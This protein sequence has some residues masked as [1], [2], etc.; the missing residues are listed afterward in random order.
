[1]I[2]P[3]PL[4]LTHP[5]LIWEMTQLLKFNFNSTRGLII[6]GL[7]V[8]VNNKV[9]SKHTDLIDANCSLYALKVLHFTEKI[10]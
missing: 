6:E 8:M 10:L 5:Y 9:A 7:G 1:M 3:L 4:D 2:F